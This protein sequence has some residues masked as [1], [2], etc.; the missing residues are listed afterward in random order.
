MGKWEYRTFVRMFMAA[1]GGGLAAQWA[2]DAKESRGADEL[3]DDQGNDGWELVS[4]ACVPFGIVEGGHVQY[5]LKRPK[6]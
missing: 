5:W 1:K 6:A 3:M 2:H 4:V